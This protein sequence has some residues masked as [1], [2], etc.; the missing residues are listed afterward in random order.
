[1]L[2]WTCWRAEP[3]PDAFPRLFGILFKTQWS[4]GMSEVSYT[5]NKSCRFCGDG[6]PKG[7]CMVG[8]GGFAEVKVWLPQLLKLYKLEVI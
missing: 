7:R 2:L 3:T 5:E 6:R 4:A 1:M 8:G